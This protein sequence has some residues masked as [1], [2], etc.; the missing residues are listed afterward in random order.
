MTKLCCLNQGN[1]RF[2][3]VSSIAFTGNLLVALRKSRFVDD[4]MRMQTW[5]R[6]ELLQMLEVVTIDSHSHVGSQSFAEFRHRLVDLVA[7]LPR[8]SARQLSSGVARN[9]SRVEQI[10]GGLGDG[11]PPAGPRGEAPVGG[12]GANGG[13]LEQH[14]SSV[15][16]K[17][18]NR[19]F[20]SMS[21]PDKF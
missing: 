19:V 4:K 13:R 17:I 5:R 12:L 9:F 14:V 21:N 8:W 16:N 6:A 2:L 18:F 10:R 7:A 3:S 20:I 15:F 1:V 11:S